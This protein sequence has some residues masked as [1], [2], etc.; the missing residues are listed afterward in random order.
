MTLPFPPPLTLSGSPLV[1]SALRLSPF[2]P[3]APP[4]PLLLQP[5][6]LL[7]GG[8]SVLTTVRG[9]TVL[10]LARLIAAGIRK[11]WFVYVNQKRTEE[12][13]KT[14]NEVYMR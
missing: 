5:L 6:L 1:S 11:C 13:S 14:M 4:A 12:E 9:S 3:S 2:S 8:T 7:L 10:S